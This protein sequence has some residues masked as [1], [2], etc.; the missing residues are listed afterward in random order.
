MMHI[1][2]FNAAAPFAARENRWHVFHAALR[3]VELER[4][5]RGSILVR[6]TL[7]RS[8]PRRRHRACAV[9]SIVRASSLTA[10]TIREPKLDT[11]RDQLCRVSEMDFLTGT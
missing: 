4:I 7:V 5:Q 1:R 6:E 11:S 3:Q 9:P 8:R 2:V 10:D